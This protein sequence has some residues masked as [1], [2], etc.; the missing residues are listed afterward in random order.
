MIWEEEHLLF[1]SIINLFMNIPSADLTLY[2][3]STDLTFHCWLHD[4][5]SYFLSLYASVTFILFHLLFRLSALT[6]PGPKATTQKTPKWVHR[7][8][9]CIARRLV[10]ENECS[11]TN[12]STHFP[13]EHLISFDI[14]PRQAWEYFKAIIPNTQEQEVVLQY[15]TN[16]I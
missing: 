12:L 10:E 2:Y 1:K 7:Q 15:N 16:G 3:P 14:L 8:S 11:L 9:T 5:Y 6:S 13:L 4:L